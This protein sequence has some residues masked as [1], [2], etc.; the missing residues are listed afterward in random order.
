[1]DTD[2]YLLCPFC[3]KVT[4]AVCSGDGI[5]NV[6]CNECG[7][8]FKASRTIDHYQEFSLSCPTGTLRHNDSYLYVPVNIKMI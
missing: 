5:D 8:S 3:K 2:V 1:M 4:K 6:H 7:N